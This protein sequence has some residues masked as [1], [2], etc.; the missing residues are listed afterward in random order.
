MK[1]L[2][3]TLLALTASSVQAKCA[4]E[5]Y[6]F[7]G[8]VAAQDSAPISGALVAVAWSEGVHGTT[9]E[10]TA[11]TDSTGRYS[12]ELPFYPWSG[13]EHGTDLCNAKLAEVAVLVAAPGFVEQQAE[14]PVNGSQTTANYSLKRTAANRHGVN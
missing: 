5:L 4:N 12:V 11:R 7:A 6:T 3:A 9:F 1:H 10:R 8:K 14:L 2:I 13:N